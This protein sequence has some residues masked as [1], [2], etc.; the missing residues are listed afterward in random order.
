MNLILYLLLVLI[1]LSCFGQ[2]FNKYNCAITSLLI[3]FVL[4]YLM[5][6]DLEKSLLIA[7][8]MTIL[9]SFIKC[10][11]RLESFENG[12]NNDDNDK[13][14]NDDNDDDNGDNGE[15]FRPKYNIATG[16]TVELKPHI[17]RSLDMN[18]PA[19]RMTP[20]QAQRA[21]HDLIKS[22][23]HLKNTMEE[24]VPNLSAAKKVIDM[25]KTIKP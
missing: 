11:L 15:K 7:A 16:K 8:S 3:I 5:T 1:I 2:Y 17:P 4:V 9:L 19:D 25:Y 20:A 22:V 14:D 18:I 13:D 6:H 12:D 23:E 24:L 10:P 21:S